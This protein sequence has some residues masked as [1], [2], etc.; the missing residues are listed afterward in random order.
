MPASVGDQRWVQTGTEAG[1]RVFERNRSGD[2]G[3][4]AMTKDELVAELE[5]R[6]LPTS[7]TKAEL[8]QRLSE[9]Q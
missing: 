1:N 7:G 2:G 3:Y 8:V 6:D 5:R 4:D 9:P